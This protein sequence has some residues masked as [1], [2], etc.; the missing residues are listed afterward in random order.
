MLKD[1]KEALNKQKEKKKDLEKRQ[2]E[3]EARRQASLLN[4]REKGA[5]V[6][7]SVSSDDEEEMNKEEEPVSEEEAAEAAENDLEFTNI[8]DFDHERTETVSLNDTTLSNSS[9]RTS[10]RCLN[11][12]ASSASS[13][14]TS[15]I[16]SSS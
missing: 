6:R 1:E 12:V 3:S 15:V 9:S 10:S 2:A 13:R 7:V 16:R 14:S 4:F 11:P 5:L 8:Q